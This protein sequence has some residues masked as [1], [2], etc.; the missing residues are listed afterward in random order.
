MTGSLF[1]AGAAI[2]FDGV[3][4]PTTLADSKTATATIPAASLGVAGTYPV[5]VVN[6][7]PGGGPSSSIAFIVAN[8]T[9]TI[10][11]VT[12]VDADGRGG[13]HA[14]RARRERVRPRERVVSFNGT[15]L[16]TAYTDG[17]HL[18]ATVPT[19][20][21]GKRGRLPRRGDE[22][23][24]RR[25]SERAGDDR[26]RVSGGHGDV[27]RP[28]E[29]GPGRAA[30]DDHRHGIGLLA[31]ATAI[32]FDGSP[33]LTT[34]VDATH[35]SAALTTQQ[36]ASGRTPSRSPWPTPPPEEGPRRRSRSA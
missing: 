25:R 4:L 22:L 21:L 2:T 23:R 6:P 29:R 7:A 16:T 18:A 8:P 34:V 36:V 27:A 19:S 1:V 26:R 9:V 15:P 28:H 14:D 30:A 31:G 10:G 17:A 3:A 20:L 5:T 35:V 12:P 32:A 24:A 13:E 11:S 33:A